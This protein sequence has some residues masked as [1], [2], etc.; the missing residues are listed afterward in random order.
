MGYIGLGTFR[1]YGWDGALGL[2]SVL[3]GVFVVADTIT[4]GMIIHLDF[5]LLIN[6]MFVDVK[7]FVSHSLGHSP[8]MWPMRQGLR[9][10]R[11]VPSCEGACRSSAIGSF[12]ISTAL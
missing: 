5:N 11:Y 10:R 1:G 7:C 4:E 8:E 6:S 2:D 12:H 9:C 3:V